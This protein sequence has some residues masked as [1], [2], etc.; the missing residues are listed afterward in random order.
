MD[1]KLPLEV[2]GVVVSDEDPAP[3]VGVGGVGEVFPLGDRGRFGFGCDVREG[4]LSAWKAL[5][6]GENGFSVAG[7]HDGAC[8]RGVANMSSRRANRWMTVAQE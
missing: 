1:P 2:S 5:C 6:C 4:R 8:R 3:V 7:E